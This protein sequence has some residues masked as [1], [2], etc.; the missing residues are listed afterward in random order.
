MKI[1]RN[2]SADSIAC[3]SCGTSLGGDSPD[4]DARIPVEPQTEVIRSGEQPEEGVPNPGEPHSDAREIEPVSGVSVASK[5][6]SRGLPD[7]L[8][9]DPRREE[10]KMP[11]LISGVG[12]RSRTP[13]KSGS[14]VP[15]LDASR[16]VS[17]SDE[18]LAPPPEAEEGAVKTHVARKITGWDLDGDDDVQGAV[19]SAESQARGKLVLIGVGLVSCLFVGLLIYGVV[20]SMR[21]KKEPVNLV[22]PKPPEEIAREALSVLERDSMDNSEETS[23]AAGAVIGKFLSAATYR[24]R[25]EFVR[26]KQRVEALMDD[27]YKRN[28]DGPIAFR[29][30]EDGWEMQA[31]KSFLITTVVAEDFSGIP[32]A[33]ER[34][35]DGNFL[36]DW[37]SFVGYCEIPWEQ[38]VE[39]KPAEPFL[40]RATASVGDY[41]NYGYVDS[42]WACVRIQDKGHIHSIY[43]YVDLSSPLLSDL[44][45]VM[46]FRGETHLTLKVVHA[47]EG[48]APNQFLIT[49]VV[50]KGWVFS[51][52]NGAPGGT[53]SAGED[54]GEVPGEVPGG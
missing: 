15:K 51:E 25:L 24:E 53:K 29:E 5:P 52:I 43:G 36:V 6:R 2:R 37:E 26:D 17:T 3:P 50:A 20:Q 35:E 27:Y 16:L 21:E 11:E 10:Y 32:T 44:K 8:I 34:Q 4:D 7:P 47:G 14:G 9:P 12:E 28:P 48:K 38:I 46:T 23:A 18:R 30:P 33:V 19:D 41:Y 13:T 40:V 1:D 54:P 45:N 39:A 31:Y 22:E 49:E 42:E